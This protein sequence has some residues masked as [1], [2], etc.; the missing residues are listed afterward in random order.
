[1]GS[2]PVFLPW[3]ARQLGRHTQDK[4][5]YLKQEGRQELTPKMTST[6]VH[7]TSPPPPNTHT[8]FSFLFFFFL[9]IYLF[10]Y[11]GLVWFLVLEVRQ[12]AVLESVMYQA[13][14]KVTEVCLPLI[15]E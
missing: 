6:C 2:I 10:I 9:F 13:D 7:S 12:K 15:P 4:R 8:F 11:F 14:L 3:M 1:M 5:P